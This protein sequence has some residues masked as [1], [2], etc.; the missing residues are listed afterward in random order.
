M[1][2]GRVGGSGKGRGM[3]VGG[4]EV[5]G[6]GGVG[7]WRERD[8]EDNTGIPL[9]RMMAPFAQTDTPVLLMGDFNFKP[10]DKRHGV[11]SGVYED[12][13]LVARAGAEYVL[14]RGTYPVIAGT[15]KHRRIDY[16]FLSKGDVVVSN[17]AVIEGEHAE[18]SDHLGYVADVMLT[19]RAN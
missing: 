7:R 4:W 14:E 16:V 3:A 9:Q 1:R 10:N 11:V 2:V 19:P 5:E 17:V 18:A 6:G 13:A 15:K 12:S 8:G